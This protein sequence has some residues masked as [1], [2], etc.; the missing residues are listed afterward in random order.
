LLNN[1]PF[2]VKEYKEYS[3]HYYIVDQSDS[4]YILLILDEMKYSTYCDLVNKSKIINKHIY[5]FVIDK[6]IYLLFDYN[7]SKTEDLVKS[8]KIIECFEKL[9]NDTS[10]E[11]ILKKENIN[12]LN[13][14][15]QLL[16]KKFIYFEFRIREIETSLYKDDLAWIILS[17]YNIIL[18][19][20]LYLY[21]L[22]Q[23][24]F[25][26]IDKEEIVKY[27]LIYKKYNLDFYQKSKILPCF[28]LYY[29]PI[30]MLYVRY[31]LE[32]C[33]EINYE[34]FND[35]INKMNLFNKKYFC[36]MVLYIYV[37]NLNFNINF[38]N[39][40]IQN[41]IYITSLIKEF[42]QKYNYII[43]Q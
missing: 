7:D 1:L 6:N 17:K 3:D 14:M 22:Q 27:G 15:Y 36:F 2:V 19:T 31:Y 38:D 23:D 10:Y 29:A 25:K 42:I 34:K 40:N 9:F 41:Y 4:K 37:L 33:K 28:D 12:N 24:I 39:Y 32:H 20:K 16:D 30:S 35:K 26:Y 11:V 5:E 8:Y 21:D 18:D 43:K 13:K